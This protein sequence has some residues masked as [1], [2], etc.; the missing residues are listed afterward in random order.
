MRASA[1]RTI[2]SAACMASKPSGV[3]TWST[4]ARS[5]ASTIELRELAADRTL[6]IDAAEH[7]MGVGQGRAVVALPVAD[8]ARH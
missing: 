3:P 5:A 4:M 8:G 2:A 6:G 7:D 1:T